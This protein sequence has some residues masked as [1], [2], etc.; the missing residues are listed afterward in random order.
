MIELSS[1]SGISLDSDE[2]YTVRLLSVD[3]GAV[4]G[5]LI[6]RT[7]VLLAF[8]SPSGVMQLYIAG[9]RHSATVFTATTNAPSAVKITDVICY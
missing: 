7:L 5:T 4:L 3:G 1:V 9:S 8:A 2:R 6:S